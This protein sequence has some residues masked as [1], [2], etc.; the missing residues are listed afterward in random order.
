MVYINHMA[1]PRTYQQ[2]ICDLYGQGYSEVQVSKRLGISASGVRYWLGKN[3]IERR[4]ISEAI[5]NWHITEF[6]KRPFKLKTNLSP[7]DKELRVAG[8]MLYWGE[9]NKGG[10]QVR[11]TNSDPEM[12]RV[13]LAF[14]RRICGVSEERLRVLVHMYPDHDEK[15]VLKFW[16]KITKI[17]L[18]QFNKSF[19]HA[20][21]K[22]TYKKKSKYGTLALTY[23]DR[24]LLALLLRWV[25]EYR[26]RFAPE[27]KAGVAQ[28]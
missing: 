11:F 25:N 14:L 7:F 28:R 6:N 22:G 2:E 9:G 24:Q 15:E 13:F 27:S 10:G 26:N 21:K 19:V 20:G 16:T 12:I 18:S 17:P 3:G 23:S 8:A 5:T 4:S 1:S